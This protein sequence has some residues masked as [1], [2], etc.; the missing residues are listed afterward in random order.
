M[1]Q[2]HRTALVLLVA[3]A[4]AACGER[5]PEFSVDEA[6]ADIADAFDL[7]TESVSILSEGPAL[8]ETLP[9]ADAEWWVDF[10]VPAFKETLQARFAG[11]DVEWLL[12]G[13]RRRPARDEQAPWGEV[14][15][16]LGEVRAAAA[17]RAA[18]TM[19]IMRALADGI[20]A[21][22][23]DAGSEYPSTDIAGLLGL[24]ER[25]RYVEG[26]QH[27]DAWGNRFHYYAPVTGESY[28]LVSRGADNRFDV[29]LDSYQTRTEAGDFTYDG[30]T[31]DPGAD[32]I[33]ALGSFVQ[34]YEP[35]E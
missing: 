9:E 11:R 8:R 13:V 15:V 21:Y 22:A 26:G 10:R 18:E 14:G 24:L 6:Q 4:G 12:E 35:G 33:F 34:R 19:E 25:G 7:E 3:L 17:E 28:I 1:T 29:P 30:L 2:R 27:S 5:R 16:M 20:E 32:I 23:V 31:S